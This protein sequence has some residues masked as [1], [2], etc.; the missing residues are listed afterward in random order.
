[1]LGALVLVTALTAC[2]GGR[3]PAAPTEP[4][5]PSPGP[6]TPAPP[7]GASTDLL[8]GEYSLTLAHGCDKVDPAAQ[9]RSYTAKIEPA[10]S[11]FMVTLSDAR[12][13]AD[14]VCT[15]E[16]RL[17]CNQFLASREQDRVRFD[18]INGEWHGGYI[19]EQLQSGTWL[20][21]YGSATG[22]LDGGAIAAAGS[23]S[24]WYCTTSQGYPFPCFSYAECQDTALRLTFLRK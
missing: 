12:F 8:V 6:T 11:G 15:S 16:S 17:G 5:S 7:P 2:G 9:V 10:A 1:M 21:V 23:G 18:L 22:R 19:T 3:P 20:V 14:S 13:F 4:A 24:V